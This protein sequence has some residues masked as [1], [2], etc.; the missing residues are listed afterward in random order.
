[1]VKVQTEAFCFMIPCSLV[2]T[3]ALVGRGESG[4]T[5]QGSNKKNLENFKL[6]SQIRGTVMTRDFFFLSPRSMLGTAILITGSG[7]QNV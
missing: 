1:M 6:L 4:A 7:C 2:G 5:A 3:W